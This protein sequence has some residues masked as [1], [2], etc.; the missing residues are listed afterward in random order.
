MNLYKER[1]QVRMEERRREVEDVEAK[2][3]ILGL[4]ESNPAEVALAMD[5]AAAAAAAEEEEEELTY[6][7]VREENTATPIHPG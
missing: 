4:N 2:R 7:Q 5:T 1:E 6:L 3:N